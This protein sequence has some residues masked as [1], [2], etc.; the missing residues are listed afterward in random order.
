MGEKGANNTEFSSRVLTEE[1][2]EAERRILCCSRGMGHRETTSSRYTL[3]LELFVAVSAGQTSLTDVVHKRGCVSNGRRRTTHGTKIGSSISTKGWSMSKLRY[4]CLPPPRRCC[5]LRPIIISPG[6]K[7]N[8][9][10]RWYYSWGS[11]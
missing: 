2:G 6:S 10:S 1:E 9:I 11:A 8:S 7:E 3:L 4:S 5:C